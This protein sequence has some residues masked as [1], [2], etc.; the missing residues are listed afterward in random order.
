M[1]VLLKIAPVL[2]SV[3]SVTGFASIPPS[4]FI[5]RQMA[6]KHAAAKGIRVRSLVSEWSDGKEGAVHF[7]TATWIHPQNGTVRSFALDDSGRKLYAIERRPET[8]PLGYAI[9]FWPSGRHLAFALKARGI[10]VKTDDELSK[11]TDESERQ[12]A[13][14]SRLERFNE[15]IAWVIGAKD[16]TRKVPQLWIE[17]DTFLPLFLVTPGETEEL[18]ELTFEGHKSFKDLSIPVQITVKKGGTS[19]LKDEVQDVAFSADSAEFKGILHTGYTELGQGAS[20]EI[21]KLIQ[22]YFEVLR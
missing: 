10:E 19:I 20:P 8:V 6:A 12:A 3:L 16:R 1:K 22:T 13:E 15:H 9:L 7:R 17:K 18:Y 14:T 11:M 4:Q 2:L 21:K 5:V